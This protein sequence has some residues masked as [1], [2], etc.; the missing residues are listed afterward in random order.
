MKNWQQITDKI[1]SLDTA[2]TLASYWKDADEKTVFTNGCFDILHRGHVTY[3][4]KAADKGKHLIV[5][6]NTDKSVKKQGK[7]KN[8]PI[9]DENSRAIV[10]AALSCV[11]LVILFDNET[12]LEIIKKLQPDVLVK[13]ADYDANINDPTNK[14]YIVGSKEV[15]AYK[16]EV[17]TIE[18]EEGFSTTTIIQKI[19][20]E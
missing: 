2:K 17:T 5:A 15:K 18:L 7:G 9:H 12:P 16:G 10:L 20:E 6:I 1:V 19:K 4:A 13:G 14:K 8:R 11:S 3:L